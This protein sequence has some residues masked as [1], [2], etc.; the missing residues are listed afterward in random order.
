VAACCRTAA[1]SNSYIVAFSMNPVYV[2]YLFG[3]RY[4]S[5]KGRSAGVQATFIFGLTFMLVMLSL[6]AGW[7]GAR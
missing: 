2:P 5:L 6:L 7:I 4:T 1:N 3:L